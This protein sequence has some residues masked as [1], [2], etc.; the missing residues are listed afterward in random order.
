MKKFIMN[1][2]TLFSLALIIVG[3]I[4]INVIGSSSSN[5]AI[6][7]SSSIASNCSKDVSDDLQKMIDKA[8]NGTNDKP[9][10]ID[11]GSGN[12][13]GLGSRD[14][15]TRGAQHNLGLQNGLLLVDRHDLT[16]TSS[17]SNPAQLREL[18]DAPVGG[19]GYHINRAGI[20]MENS[21]NITISNIR[22]T[23]T[24]QN[25]G[26]IASSGMEQDHNVRITGGSLITLD[27][28]DA[29]APYGDN[30]YIGA[31]PNS[32]GS[33]PV[34]WGPRGEK[35][36]IPTD[37]TVKDS[38]LTGSGRHNVG[39]VAGN[40]IYVHDNT[41]RKSGY[42]VFDL[43]QQLKS[44]PI[45][46]VII[47]NNTANGSH[48]G[49]A[50]MNVQGSTN[51]GLKD[52]SIDNNS[53]KQSQTCY[54]FATINSNSTIASMPG[55]TSNISITNNAMSMNQYGVSASYMS[56][57]TVTG[58]TGYT[59]SSL[60]CGAGDS[61]IGATKYF[62]MLAAGNNLDTVKVQDNS[63]LNMPNDMIKTKSLIQKVGTKFTATNVTDCSNNTTASA[64]KVF[65]QPKVC[66]TSS[67]PPVVPIPPQPP[68]PIPTPPAPVSPVQPKP[69][70]STGP[71]GAGVAPS[72]STLQINSPS[73]NQVIK[74]ANGNRTLVTVTGRAAAS[75]TVEV[76]IIGLKQRVT[77]DI[78]GDWKARYTL[79]T[80][81]FTVSVTEQ[82]GDITS[83]PISTQF[84]IT[85]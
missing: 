66:S 60:K 4:A 27:N 80:G 77:A 22:F 42:W 59:R 15:G 68:T 29:S 25:G 21:S 17:S 23:G 18:I 14:A 78:H 75:S 39:I 32:S 2:F 49:F 48:F 6:T 10:V 72:S 69:P 38:T 36:N 28:I 8:P 71:V 34:P 13:F 44:V 35:A 5:A 19:D 11:L 37:I 61:D 45:Q 40:G 70:I 73:Q 1:K 76:Q 84:R 41:M 65:D 58:N 12:C 85:N 46:D 81:P 63:Y 82:K 51:T 9:T 52:I 16:I 62:A 57:L 31:G 55:P 43:E 26:Y 30:V 3:V 83:S 74:I 50:A 33:G 24:N 7:P 53:Y 54:E 56:N 67:K 20:W 79:S 64:S 47:K